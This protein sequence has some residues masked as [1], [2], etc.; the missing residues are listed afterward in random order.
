MGRG[1]K[2]KRRATEYKN[3]DFA[4][5][6]NEDFEDFYKLQ[7]LVPEGEWDDFLKSLKS[8]LPGAWRVNPISSRRE[9]VTKKLMEDFFKLRAIEA[10]GEAHEGLKFE[11]PK[12][13][14]WFP[15]AWTMS[16]PRTKLRKIERA[17]PFRSWLMDI[18][19]LG[20]VTRQELV[21]M[22]PP[23]VLDVQSH[24]TVL[25]MCAAPGSKTSQLLEAVHT[26]PTGEYIPKPQGFVMANE[27]DFKRNNVMCSQI[28]RLGLSNFLVIS[29]MGQCIPNVLLDPKQPGGKPETL[30]FDRILCDVPCSGDGT[31][32]KNPDLWLNWH[33][34]SGTCLHK[35]QLNI[36]RRGGQMLKPGGLMVYSTCSLNPI[37]DEAV[38]AEILRGNPK[39]ELVDLSDKLEGLKKSPGVSTW[40]VSDI[41][42]KIYENVG[43]VR[44]RHKKRLVPS[45]FPP[46]PE[47]AS[48]FALERT[49]RILP[50]HNDTG[51]FFVAL[52]RKKPEPVVESASPAEGKQQEEEKVEEPADESKLPT[53]EVRKCNYS[54]DDHNEVFYG[55]SSFDE[56]K[57]FLRDLKIYYGITDGFPMEELFSRDTSFSKVFVVPT[58]TQRVIKVKEN[59]KLKLIQAGLKVFS[60]HCAKMDKWPNL[61]QTK[62]KWRITQS[63]LHLI[64]PH[65]TKQVVTIPLKHFR[66]LVN[67]KQLYFK[68]KEEKTPEDV[69]LA[70]PDSEVRRSLEASL[71]GNVIVQLD[72]SSDPRCEQLDTAWRALTTLRW[73]HKL[74]LQVKKEEVRLLRK[75]LDNIFGKVEPSS[76]SRTQTRKA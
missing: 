66:T 63:G 59:Q 54:L 55:L 29:R 21:S 68:D 5:V 14:S 42:R 16:F 33:R 43:E 34:N 22:I 9:E 49:M 25:D 64:L 52:L 23:L 47:E 51:G 12:K 40:K 50:H 58:T 53:G 3:V 39:L 67:D 69:N 24:H 61:G 75:Q 1:R 13:C 65:I 10:D 57:P 20:H 70:I 26:S 72:M 37:E 44:D 73:P 36:A 6:K 38:V 62:R 74:D 76:P 41:H 31:F 28:Q 19:A 18:T 11:A 30:Y 27:P 60:K 46:T 45:L 8:P 35:T 4:T 2:R 17:K 56:L 71:F 15:S 32:R 7:G 48:R